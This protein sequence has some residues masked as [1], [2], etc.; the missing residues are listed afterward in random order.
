MAL[1]KWRRRQ[2]RFFG[3]TWVPVAQIELRSNSGA[4]QAIA[5]QV[6]SGA[7]VSILR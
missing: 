3:E 6:D 4:F 2:T 7:V 1:Y 5:L